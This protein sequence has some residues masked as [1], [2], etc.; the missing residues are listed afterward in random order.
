MPAEEIG[1]LAQKVLGLLNERSRLIAS[2]VKET[3]LTILKL[4]RQIAN[5][6][7]A[8]QAATGSQQGLSN[9][10]RSIAGSAAGPLAGAGS[11]M[12][13][14]GSFVTPELAG[15]F[16]EMNRILNAPS[17]LDLA[18]TQLLPSIFGAGGGLPNAQQVPGGLSPL[19]EMSPTPGGRAP[20]PTASQPVR[21]LPGQ[22]QGSKF[23]GSP[24]DQQLPGG[25]T[26][27]PAPP[28]GT[29]PVPSGPQRNPRPKPNWSSSWWPTPK[30][31][32]PATGPKARRV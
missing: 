5:A 19:P 31:P 29:L 4:D 22:Q 27:Q 14:V 15:Q 9:L 3:A 30:K 25:G 17:P 20:M 10:P 12:P 6:R 11:F 23:P 1:T 16:P 24:M 21:F 18:L 8:E 2:G 28:A 7:L 13:P 26:R 32:K